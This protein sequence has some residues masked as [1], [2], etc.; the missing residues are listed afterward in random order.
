M[1]EI[2]STPIW[3]YQYKNFDQQYIE[4]VLIEFKKNNPTRQKSNLH[5]YQSDSKLT[6]LVELHPLFNWICSRS[7]DALSNQNFV[8]NNLN[9]GAW[10][11]FNETR[12]A[13]NYP[14][15]HEGTLSGV[16]Y[17]KAPPHSGRLIL[18]NPGMNSLWQGIKFCKEKSSFTSEAVFVEPREGD[19]I[20]FPSYLPHFVE[21]NLHDDAR[22]S[23]SFNIL[24]E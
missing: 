23:I 20:L 12:S 3:T 24:L 15:A 17:V 6:D 10:C 2:F 13:M 9:I 18:Q 19:L 5:G 1:K 21:P 11:N 8:F 14:H 7:V 4:N 22:I 16:F